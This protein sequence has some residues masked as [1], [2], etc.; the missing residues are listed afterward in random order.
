MPKLCGKAVQTYRKTPWKTRVQQSTAGYLQQ[1]I[2]VT[3]VDKPRFSHLISA[4]IH[5][6]SPQPKTTLSPLFEHNFYPVSTG[7]T[8]T[9]TKKRI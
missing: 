8:I 3:Y 7:P 1:Q 6:D 9:T 5:M 2:N 4:V